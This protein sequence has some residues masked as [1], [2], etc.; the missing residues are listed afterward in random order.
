[1]EITLKTG[2]SLESGI[3]FHM[4]MKI[5][6]RVFYGT[7]LV[8]FGVILEAQGLLLGAGEPVVILMYFGTC[9]GGSQIEVIRS[10]GGFASVPGV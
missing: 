4:L 10:V 9:P 6:P 2:A 5:A 1:M 8:T 7:I 3:D